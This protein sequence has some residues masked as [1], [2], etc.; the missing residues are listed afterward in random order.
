MRQ[1]NK[2]LRSVLILGLLAVTVGCTVSRGNCELMMGTEREQCIR[3]NA[4]NDAA[5]KS[6]AKANKESDKPLDLSP[7]EDREI[8]SNEKRWIP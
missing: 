2:N 6:R 4:S 7:K 3:A 8:D 5:L 1:T